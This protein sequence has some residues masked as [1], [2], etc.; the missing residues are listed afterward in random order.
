MFDKK[1]YLKKWNKEH[2]TY[3]KELRQKNLERIRERDRLHYQRNKDKIKARINK[4]WNNKKQEY[5][6]QRRERYQKDREIILQRNKEYYQNNKKTIIESNKKYH[7]KNQNKIKEWNKNFNK[8]WYKENKQRI[9]IIKKEYMKNNPDILLKS[10]L[11]YLTKLADGFS[12]TSHQYK[13]AL[14][15]WSKTIRRRDQICVI[16]GST[17]KL[18]AHHIIHRAKNPELSFVKNNGVLLCKKHHDEVHEKN[19]NI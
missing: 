16:C 6:A 3:Q 19:L 8:K 15:A 11:N 1:E 18:N 14:S 7:K 10:Q 12:L 9:Q 17:E 13:L 4:Q 5:N 2:P